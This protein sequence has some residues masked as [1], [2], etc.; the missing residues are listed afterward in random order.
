M[1]IANHDSVG[2]D[3]IGGSGERLRIVTFDLE[4]FDQFD[5]NDPE[6]VRTRNPSGAS[7]NLR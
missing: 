6:S 2:G 3:S 5:G 1:R 4:L 7:I